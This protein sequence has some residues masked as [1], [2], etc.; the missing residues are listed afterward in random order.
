MTRLAGKTALVTGAASGIGRA[1]TFAFLAQ[2]ADVVAV[3]VDR[4][5]LGRLADGSPIAGSVPRLITVTADVTDESSLNAAVDRGV[6]EF[7]AYDIV[8]A[9]AGRGS[10]STIVDTPLEEWS[11]VIGLCLTGVFLTLKSA[12]RHLADAASLITIASLNA[13]QPAAGMAAYCAAKAGAAALTNVAALEFGARGIRANTIAP[14]LIETAAS[15][16]F[17]QIPGVVEEFIDN[18]TI[19]RHGQ[20]DD[21][22]ALAVF[23]ASDE[24][25]FISGS[26]YSVDGGASTKRYPDL[27]AAIGRLSRPPQ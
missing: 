25:S 22:A 19:G 17:W 18:T 20:P 24:S 14:G 11:A 9:N 3:D 2:G 10:F 16:A 26:L 15:G 27:P 4:D 6:D 8:V 23:L 12:G 13:I 7:G 1:I 5:G 21:V